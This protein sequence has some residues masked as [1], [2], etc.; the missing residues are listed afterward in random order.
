[1]PLDGAQVSQPV[2]THEERCKRMFDHWWN[3]KA[4]S[5]TQWV[6]WSNEDEE[7]EP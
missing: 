5:G 7:Y 2:E 6:G 3:I 4:P 1:M